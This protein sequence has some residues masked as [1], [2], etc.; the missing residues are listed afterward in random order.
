VQ[1]GSSNEQGVLIFAPIYQANAQTLDFQARRS[2][3]KGYVTLVLRINEAVNTALAGLERSQFR[4]RL[5][6]QTPY[7]AEPKLLYRDP[8]FTDD[9]A[10]SKASTARIS[11]YPI[12]F[13]FYK[14]Q[15][16]FLIQPTG[17]KYEKSWASWLAMNGGLALTALLGG[18]L[19]ALTGRQIETENLNQR[20]TLELEKATLA[21]AEESAK[22]RQRELDLRIT[23]CALETHEGI[24]IADAQAKILRVNQAFIQISGYSE[25]EL[26]GKTPRLLQSHRHGAAFYAALWNT[27]QASGKWQGEIWNRRKNG[28]LYPEWLT[29][30]AVYSEDKTPSHYVGIYA[31]IMEYQQTLRQGKRLALYDPL[32]GLPNRRLLLERLGHECAAHQRQNSLAA[33]LLIDLNHFKAINAFLGHA[34]GDVLLEQAGQRLRAVLRESDTPARIGRDEFAAILPLLGREREDAIAYTLNVAARILGCFDDPF[35]LQSHSQSVSVSIGA[36]LFPGAV[37]KA[38][39]LLRQADLAMQEARKKGHNSLSFYAST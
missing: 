13:V 3:L 10:P 15:W 25:K 27:L 30:Y 38:E 28:E 35:E 2:L 21:L 14:T 4:V 18:Y 8:G 31:D 36:V 39:E 19:L 1:G 6:E 32:T 37:Y 12:R 7:D 16:E 22:R 24:L 20:K 33:L 17:Q 26:L 11:A 9:T 34:L 5:Q 23:A 29:I